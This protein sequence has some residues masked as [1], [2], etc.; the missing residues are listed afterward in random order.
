[1]CLVFFHNEYRHEGASHHNGLQSLESNDI[2]TSH[3]ESVFHPEDRMIS[4]FS[5]PEKTNTTNWRKKLF[6][7]LLVI[8]TN[9]QNQEPTSSVS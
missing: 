9:P 6:Q 1:M 8:F 4:E 2:M 5:I 7:K 3:Y